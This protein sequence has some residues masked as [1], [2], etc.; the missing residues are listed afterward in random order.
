[1]DKMIIGLVFPVYNEEHGIEVALKNIKESVDAFPQH[2][3]KIYTSDDCSTDNTYQ[4]LN[5]WGKTYNL[6]MVIHKGEM[7]IGAAQTSKR[8]FQRIEKTPDIT[9]VIKMDLDADLNQRAVIK[10]MIPY[11]NT[12]IDFAVGIR[13]IEINRNEDTEYEHLRREDMQRILR[14]EFSLVQFDAASLGC[15]FLNRQYLHTLLEYSAVANHDKRWGWEMVCLLSTVHAKGIPPII[16]IKD[17][18]YSL[19]RRPKEK[20]DDQYD[21]D[22]ETVANLTGKNPQSLSSFYSKK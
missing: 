15:L 21:I 17:C 20:I 7:N 14:E 16:Q 12:P 11:V 1:M 18:V 2:A 3:F 13:N 9:H 10:K 5:D 22:I 19:S 4:A 6:D 8:T